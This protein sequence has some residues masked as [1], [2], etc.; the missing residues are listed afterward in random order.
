MLVSL[1]KP[2]GY[3]LDAIDGHIGRCADFLIDDA[4]WVVRWMVADTGNWLPGRKVLVSPALLDVPDWLHHRLPVRLTREQIEA[5]PP[6]DDDA[7]ISRRYEQAYNAFHG[8]PHYWLGSNLWGHY[9]LPSSMLGPREAADQP[10]SRVPDNAAL[11][12]PMTTEDEDRI[13]LRS[14]REITG[15]GVLAKPG[16]ADTPATER[17]GRI[18]DLIIDERTWAVRYV[19]VDRSWLPLSKHVLLPVELVRDLDWTTQRLHAAATEQQVKDAPSV[20]HG[21]PVTDLLA[22]QTDAHYGRPQA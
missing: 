12:E 9:P 10:V 16:D 5:A 6:L 14:L 13:A 3:R 21:E 20:E 1:A 17:V 19:V 4:C 15:Y 22:T 18:D 2:E 8:L 7:P 11:T